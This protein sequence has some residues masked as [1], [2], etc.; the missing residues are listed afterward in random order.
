[1]HPLT[2]GLDKYSHDF[3]PALDL[4]LHAAVGQ[5]LHEAGDLKFPGDLERRIAKSDALHSPRKYCSLVM[6]VSHVANK[7]GLAPDGVQ[8]AKQERLAQI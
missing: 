4:D 7:V 3:R 1:M 8:S 6:H 5:V 2:D